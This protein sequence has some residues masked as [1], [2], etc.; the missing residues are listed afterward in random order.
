MEDLHAQMTNSQKQFR[1]LNFEKST[2]KAHSTLVGG[3]GACLH[4]VAVSFVLVLEDVKITQHRASVVCT[5]PE[6]LEELRVACAVIR[7]VADDDRGRAGGGQLFQRQAQPVQQRRPAVLRAELTQ[8]VHIQRVWDL[9]G[10]TAI[11][12][13]SP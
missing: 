3:R 11:C 8:L 4:D 10:T 5:A 1:K 6:V 2:R 7:G 12:Q 13:K 9:P